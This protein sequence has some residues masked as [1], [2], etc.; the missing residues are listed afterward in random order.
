MVL[1]SVRVAPQPT[2]KSAAARAAAVGSPPTRCRV[3]ETRG[4]TALARAMGRGL[5]LRRIVLSY[6][7]RTRTISGRRTDAGNRVRRN[8]LS[9]ENHVGFVRRASIS[10]STTSR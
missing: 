7:R 9:D 3:S 2:A 8:A 1:E 6:E 5:V 4:L 10:G